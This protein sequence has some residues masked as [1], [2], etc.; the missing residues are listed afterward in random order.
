MGWLAQVTLR[1]W[2]FWHARAPAAYPDE[3]GYLLAARWLA[4]RPGGDLSHLTFYQGGYPLLLSPVY[5]VTADPETVYRLVTG[6]GAITG[7]TVFPLSVAILRRL[8]LAPSAAAAI[9]FAVASLPANLFFGAWALTDAILPAVVMAWLLALIRFADAGHSRSGSVASLAAAY[10]YAVH[11]R[12]IVILLIHAGVLLLLLVRGW[13]P[14]RVTTLAA[15][16]MVAMWAGANRLNTLLLHA[17][18]PHGARDLSG[19][20]SSRLTS[21]SGLLRTLSGA[22]GQIWYLTTSTYGLAG[23]GLV[24]A[25]VQVLSPRADRTLRLVAG[26]AVTVT[27]GIALASTA[28]L[29][30]EHRVGNHAYG[31]YL[32]CVAVPLTLAAAAFLIRAGRRGLCAAALATAGVMAGT[33][34]AVVAYAGPRL[35]EDTFVGFDFPEIIYLT[36]NRHSLDLLTAGLVAGAI[37]VCV[38]L[39]RAWPTCVAAVLLVVNG[40][41]LVRTT[42]TFDRPA[43]DRPAVTRDRGVEVSPSLGWGTVADLRYRVGWT[44]VEWLSPAGPRPGTC[45][46]V[47]AWHAGAT[48][49]AWPDHPA[50]WK[51]TDREPGRWV[52]WHDTRCRHL[53]AGSRLARRWRGTAFQATPG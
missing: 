29:P 46:V 20:L 35:H 13:T 24:A 33:A 50:G 3:A 31:R 53:V 25:L 38:V 49:A 36:A 28:A 32:A 48:T 1:V 14:R 52:A 44:T 34:L 45:T 47:T 7:A 26:A 11:S 43:N 17:L 5:L 4:G 40:G 15:A 12:G 9:A 2:A 21:T 16:V 18:Y 51:V 23:L 6:I 30:D 22:C 37:G 19:V 41:F 8:D 39:L 42:G 10:A 27:V